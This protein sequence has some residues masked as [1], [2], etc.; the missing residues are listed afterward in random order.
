MFSTSILKL[1]STANTPSTDNGTRTHNL[2]DISVPLSP[3]SYI[4][5]L[6]AG[7]GLEPAISAYETE[8]ITIFHIPLCCCDWRTRTSDGWRPNSAHETDAAP[9]SQY[10]WWGDGIEPPAQDVSNLCS[11]Y[12]ATAPYLRLR[13]SV[14]P[15]VWHPFIEWFITGSN[16]FSFLKGTTRIRDSVG[17][18]ISLQS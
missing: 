16:Y 11:T 13:T 10:L 1:N 15:Q 8:R 12:W 5:I 6:V 9:A 2:D 18:P 14:L 4:G 7:A 3:L 17:V